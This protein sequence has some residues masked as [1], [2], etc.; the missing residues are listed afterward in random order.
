[1]NGRGGL[2]SLVSTLCGVAAISLATAPGALATTT[3]S[4]TP[5]WDG[6]LVSG[7]GVAGPPIISPRRMA[8]R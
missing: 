7:F 6:S 8:R 4:N 1:M 2:R 3:I 5:P